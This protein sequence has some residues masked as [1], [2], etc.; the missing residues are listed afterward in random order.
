[1]KKK[2]TIFADELMA[3]M[4][5]PEKAFL[6]IMSDSGWSATIFDSGMDSFTQDGSGNRKIEF[7][8]KPGFM[9]AYSISVQ[10]Q[11][12]TGRLGVV[13]IQN[14][15]VLDGGNTNAAYGIVSLAGNCGESS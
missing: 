3:S 8:C 9:S 15:D 14:L 1:M 10:K 11:S 12:E 7:E 2:G 5:I 4:K 13:I 6:Y